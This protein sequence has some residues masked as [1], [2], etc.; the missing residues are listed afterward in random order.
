MRASSQSYSSWLCIPMSSSLH[1]EYTHLLHS[2]LP[3]CVQYC[4]PQPVQYC[5]SSPVFHCS[6]V[7]Y[8]YPVSYCPPVFHYYPIPYPVNTP[9]DEPKG[10]EESTPLFP[11]VHIFVEI[12]YM[13]RLA[14]LLMSTIFYSQ[15]T[16]SKEF[17][18]L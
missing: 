12:P 15:M 9:S 2:C 17:K 11:H 1:P 18:R 7:S 13:K 5:S 8:C 6:L 14:F 10:L 3:D 4:Y 16:V